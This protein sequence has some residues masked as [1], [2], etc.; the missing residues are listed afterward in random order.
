LPSGLGTMLMSALGLPP[1]KHI[2]ELRSRLQALFEAGTIEGG[3]E[4][5][6]YV[7]Q[8]REHNLLVGVVDLAPG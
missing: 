7:E 1:G 3:R 5:E 6:Y 2:G 8:V 4:A